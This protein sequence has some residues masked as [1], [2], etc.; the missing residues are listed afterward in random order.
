MADFDTDA[1]HGGRLPLPLW[2]VPVRI[3]VVIGATALALLALLTV[4]GAVDPTGHD[5][6]ATRI[7][8]GLVVSVI[9]VGLILLLARVVERRPLSDL[10]L[11]TPLRDLRAFL[12]GIAVWTVPAALTFGLLA[13]FG[14]PLRLIAPAK[15]FWLV[16]GLLFL[17]VLLSEAIPEELVFRGYISAVLAE[18]LSP[19]WVIGVQTVLF[20][21]T[22]IALRGSFS[23]LD[24][25][26]FVA[27]GFVLGYVRLVS[28]SVW[29]SIGI[30][31]AF[32]TASQ[33]ILTHGVVGFDGA[34]VFVL[35]ALGAV[36]FTV[37]AILVPSLP[38]SMWGS[39]RVDA[40]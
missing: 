33:L 37:A 16:L 28:E 9:V 31:V 18:R 25:S 5:T 38:R 14:S 32:Q 36:P 10:G 30:H 40:T 20:A 19:W 34:Q 22:A 29:T 4:D 1:A 12:L 17:A 21:A 35:L 24:A 26:L 39:H 15:E 13:L 7:V 27:M 2:S 3:A 6:I 8:A 23:P 11:T